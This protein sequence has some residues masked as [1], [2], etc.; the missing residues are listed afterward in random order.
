M[1]HRAHEPIAKLLPST[2]V[3]GQSPAAERLD[4]IYRKFD[5]DPAPNFITLDAYKA[6]PFA[7]ALAN[8]DIKPWLEGQT[9]TE[10]ETEE[11]LKLA[12]FL[13]A[14]NA[15]GRDKIT[16]LLPESWSAAAIET[17]RAF[18][19]LNLIVNEKVTPR[20]FH[21]PTEPKQDRVFLIVQRKGEPDPEAQA[22]KNLRT[23][24]YPIAALTFAAKEPLSHY[25]RFMEVTAAALRPANPTDNTREAIAAELIEEAHRE[26]GIEHTA[27]WKAL[28]RETPKTLAASISSAAKSRAITC[29]EIA[30]FGDLHYA[31]HAPVLRKIL[32]GAA[33]L[34]FRTPFKM[35]AN[36]LEAPA[37]LLDSH[38]NCFTILVISASQSR[39]ALAAFEPDRHI[40]DFLAAR[41]ALEKQHRL[42]RAIL[43]KDLNDDSIAGLEQFFSLTAQSLSTGTRQSIPRQSMPRQA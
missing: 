1:Q 10:A 30:F 35:P 39:F 37:E 28:P 6:F 42:V 11:A 22:I 43:V 19:G 2:L 38:D 17:R 9:L 41:L 20:Q 15:E 25:L 24:G 27:A 16:L 32:D 40:A 31:A 34:L 14:Q 5:I 4:F 7:L 36:V 33:R 21:W 8:K 18:A 3:I 13:K 26:G 29:G 12:A 23:A